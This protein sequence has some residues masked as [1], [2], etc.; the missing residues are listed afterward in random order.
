MISEFVNAYYKNNNRDKARDLAQRVIAKFQDEI[1]HYKMLTYEERGANVD[2]I[3]AAISRYNEIIEIAILHED[4]TLVQQEAE[5]YDNYVK[6]FPKIFG[7]DFL[8]NKDA[9][10]ENENSELDNIF[11]E[12]LDNIDTEDLLETNP[13]ETP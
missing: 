10:I 2:N 4:D 1:D 9:T 13:Q 5:T 3:G 8:I 12:A 11:Q 6:E 7:D